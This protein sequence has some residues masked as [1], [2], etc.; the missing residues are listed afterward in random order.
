MHL[1]VLKSCQ[2]P[3][4][5]AKAEIFLKVLKSR[6]VP[7]KAEMY[8]EGDSSMR[9]FGLGFFLGDQ[10]PPGP[11]SNPK[12]VYLF[13]ANSVRYWRIPFYSPHQKCGK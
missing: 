1:K 6:Q 4:G 8:I 7:E 9:F 3:E 11:D 10:V 2:V 13:S 5:A 12:T